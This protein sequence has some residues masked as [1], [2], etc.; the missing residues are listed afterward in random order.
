VPR[1]LLF[2][3]DWAPKIG[4]AH[5]WMQEV[6]RRW[7]SP[8]VVVTAADGGAASAQ[9]AQRVDALEVFRVATE[10]TS[11][12]VS[13]DCGRAFLGNARELV[14]RLGHDDAVVHC[15]TTFPEGVSALIAKRRRRANTHLVVYVHGEELLIARSSRLI[16]MLARWVLRGADT[17]IA[18]SRNTA[19]MIESFVPGRS[20]QVVHPGVDAAAHRVGPLDRDTM[21]A[22]LGAADAFVVITVGRLEAR[23]NH[24]TVLGAIARLR[25]EGRDI[26]YWCV[27]EGETRAALVALV[28]ANGWG[29]WVYFTGRVDDEERRRLVAAADLHA[30]PSIDEGGLIEGFGI[31]FLEAAA[32]GVPSIAGNNGGQAEAVLD[33]RT[34]RVVDGRDVEAVAGAIRALIGD[35]GARAEM[36]VQ[37][38]A[39]AAQNDWTRV[40]TRT[41]DALQVDRAGT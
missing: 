19:S 1:H 15:K 10:I 8:V 33:G 5:H 20:V 9:V 22:R 11:I 29:D 2:S 38:V 39:W 4:G 34:G 25:G 3:L 24:R 17:V 7:P 28:A 14:Q 13:L 36:A 6:Y 37:C 16:S 18:N 23:K 27:G 40:V 41:I 21:R 32:A 31:V 26:R 12:D 30:M 35:P